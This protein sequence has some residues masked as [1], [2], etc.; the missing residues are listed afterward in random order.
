MKTVT[1]AVSVHCQ[2]V[3]CEYRF[4]L[5]R[6][7]RRRP[8]VFLCV[9][10]W[11]L[12][13]NRSATALSLSRSVTHSNSI[14]HWLLLFKFVALSLHPARLF[15]RTPFVAW[16]CL[17]VCVFHTVWH[18]ALFIVWCIARDWNVYGPVLAPKMASGCRRCCALKQHFRPI[19]WPTRKRTLGISNVCCKKV[20]HSE[21][22]II[23]AF[24]RISNEISYFPLDF[25]YPF[26]GGILFECDDDQVLSSMVPNHCNHISHH[27][28]CRCAACIC[29]SNSKSTPLWVS[30]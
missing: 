18:I 10:L 4:A 17:C 16:K 15:A 28:C 1:A 29:Q 7:R 14:A 24:A 20:S 3:N 8:T 25:R 11:K 13:H 26:L 6:H 9:H 12:H 2:R 21:C 23:S 22:I 27:F 5:R 19:V 30:Y